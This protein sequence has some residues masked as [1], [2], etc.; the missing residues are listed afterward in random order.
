MLH[1]LIPRPVRRLWSE[2]ALW[3]WCLILAVASSGMIW[4]AAPP[5]LAKAPVSEKSVP[6]AAKN[7]VALR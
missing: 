6:Q 5:P 3:R 4:I 1:R 7:A 2:A